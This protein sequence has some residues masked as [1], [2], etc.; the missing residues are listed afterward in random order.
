[1]HGSF[2]RG[3]ALAV[4]LGFLG[5]GKLFALAVTGTI[6]TALEQFESSVSNYNLVSLGNAT[7]ENYSQTEAGLAVG[8]N[9]TLI[10]TGA[11]AAQPG[12]F[13]LNG[14]PTLY[15]SGSLSLTGTAMLNSGY[16]SIAQASGY[17]WNAS[18][19]DLS[20]ATGDL[21]VTNAGSGPYSNSSPLSNPGPAGWNWSTTSSNLLNAANVLSAA[22]V[23]GTISVNSQNLVLTANGTPTAG[24]VVVFELDANLLGTNTYNGQTLSNIS[25]NVPADVTY[26][27]N[28]VNAGGKTVF[29]SG[30][31]FNSGSNDTSLIWNIEGSGDVTLGGGQFYGAV[32]AP[33]VSLSNVANTKFVGQVA[34]ASFTDNDASMNFEQFVS[35]VAVPEPATFALWGLGLCGLAILARRRLEG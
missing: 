1:M 6:G 11:I 3:F 27:I 31:N 32:L 24:S 9:L 13:G 18:N 35:A 7:F 21:N 23:T 34:A 10:G 19:H 26:V 12:T 8:G 5:G 20:G 30:V 14:N 22:A 15:V 29:G 2:R 33:S 25:I 28:V 17:V 4:C 16:A